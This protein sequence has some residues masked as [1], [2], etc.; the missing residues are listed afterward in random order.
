MKE[1]I[2]KI[3][4]VA[5]AAIFVFSLYKIIDIKLAQSREQEAF[6][7]LKEEIKPEPAEKEVS[8]NIEK[9]PEKIEYTEYKSLYDEN[10]DFAAW[11]KNPAINVDYPVMWTPKKADYYIRRDFNKEDALAGTPFIGKNGD[12]DS[13]LFIIYAHNMSNST[14]FSNLDYYKDEEFYRENP[15]FS[16]T[17]ITEEREYEIFSALKTKVPI[18]DGPAFYNYSGKLTE[19]EYNEIKNW[20]IENSIYDT[21]V[22]PLFGEQI[23]ILSTC[24]YHTDDGRFLVAARRVK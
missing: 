12:V 13:D 1:N 2:R 23:L 11:I 3:I 6:E 14:M 19:E 15:R 8:E 21:G 20:L 10:P 7:E 22:N 17:T 18:E 5:L 24:A 9:E 4:I 16:L